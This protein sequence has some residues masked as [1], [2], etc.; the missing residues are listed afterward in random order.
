MKKFLSVLIFLTVASQAFA[1]TP[2]TS[3]RINQKIGVAWDYTATDTSEGA[4]TRFEV[5]IDNGDWTDTGLV[6]HAVG[7]TYVFNTAFSTVGTHTAAVRACNAT[8]CGTPATMT[9]SVLPAI[10]TAPR[11]PRFVPLELPITPAEAAGM[12]N[13]YSFLV[14]L[15][16]FT[17]EELFGI[18][19][20]YDGTMPLTQAKV[21]DFLDR[22]AW[23]Q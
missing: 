5:Q 22:Y 16:N 3:A 13:A 20:A 14:R 10:P 6:V 12:A 4:V 18:T 7:A 9:I 23:P 8:E 19:R 2:I 17:N 1:Q 11:N 21:L 15:R